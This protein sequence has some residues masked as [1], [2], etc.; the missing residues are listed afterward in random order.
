MEAERAKAIEIPE[1]AAGKGRRLEFGPRRFASA[2]FLVLLLA[3]TGAAVGILSRGGSLDPAAAR[4]PDLRWLGIAALLALVDILIAGWRLHVLAHRIAPRVRLRDCVRASLANTCLAGLTPS[5][6]GG[7]AA[8]LYVLN[9]AGLP[10][11]AGVAIASIN[12]L[13]SIAVLAVA[14]GFALFALHDVLPGWLRLSTAWTVAALAALVLGIAALLRWGQLA[15]SSVEFVGGGRIRRAVHVARKFLHDSLEI[16]RELFREH[17]RHTA[18]MLP[19]TGLVYVAKLAFTFAIFRAF[20]PTGHLADMVGALIVLV[21]ALY[22]APTPGAAGLAEGATTAYLA[23]SLGTS[24]AAGFALWWRMLALYAPVIF[25][26]F[27]IL[28]ELARDARGISGAKRG[29]ET[30]AADRA[31]PD[32]RAA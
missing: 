3:I 2:L 24:A 29:T 10:W 32:R 27:V 15:P 1:V 16:A 18:A 14:G 8:Q 7:G 22:F 9:R 30:R 13:A 19:V 17:P 4:P 5:Q 25:G 12:F 23:G 26:G 31:H 20:C 21:L 28:T 11:R 6:A